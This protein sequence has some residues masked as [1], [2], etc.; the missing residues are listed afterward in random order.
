[1]T[2]NP[3]I[4]DTTGSQTVISHAHAEIH[5]GKSFMAD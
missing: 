3:L 4:D 5:A 2:G 1:M